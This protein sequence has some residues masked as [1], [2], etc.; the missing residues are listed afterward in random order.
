MTTQVSA[1]AISPIIHNQLPVLTTELL[2]NLYGT[3]PDYI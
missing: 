1:A 3:E 2:A